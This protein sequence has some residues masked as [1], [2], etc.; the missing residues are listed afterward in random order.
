MIRLVVSDVDG[1][2][3]RHDKSV[4]PSTVAAVGRLRAAGVKLALV[5]SRP[6]QGLDS[7]RGPL[8]LDT[9]RAG[10]NGGAIEDASGKLVE[11]HTIA[12]AACRE[13]VSVCEAAGADVWVF[14]AGAWFLTNPDTQYVPREHRA[15]GMAW[16]RVADFSGHLAGVHKIMASSDDPV[17]TAHLEHTLQA[18]IGT[19]ASVLRS[20]SYYVDVTHP[21][22]NKGNAALSLAR[23]LGV[24]PAETACLGDAP[25]DVPMFRVAGFSVA[26]GNAS[27]EV[28]AQAKAVT[29]DN[30]SDGWAQAID[31]F[32]L[33][34]G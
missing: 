21:A 7:L 25:N 18:R 14:A 1:T 34:A 3:L 5:S 17:L 13:A 4:A 27:D 15:T 33:A 24:P 2:L 29:A 30:E 10:F 11:E 28:K 12:E 9:P 26:M 8:G 23:L 32:I 22:A 6:P 20:Q 16:Q 31:R 19:Q